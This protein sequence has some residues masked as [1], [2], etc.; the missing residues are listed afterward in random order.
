MQI[1]KFYIKSAKNCNL[2]AKIRYYAIIFIM[3]STYFNVFWNWFFKLKNF[4]HNELNKG[5]HLI[6]I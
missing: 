6:S 1:I 4:L 2:N 3:H 5:T